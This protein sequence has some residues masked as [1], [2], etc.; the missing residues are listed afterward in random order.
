MDEFLK[1]VARAERK[2]FDAERALAAA[3]EQC[4]DAQNEIVAAKNT[5]NDHISNEIRRH[6]VVMSSRPATPER[7][8]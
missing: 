5:L 7:T 3:Q 6:S 8:R 1:N 2:L 4:S